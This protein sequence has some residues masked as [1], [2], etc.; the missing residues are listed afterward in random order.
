MALRSPASNLNGGNPATFTQ[1]T[2]QSLGLNIRTVTGTTTATVTD[3]TVL[4]NATT[5]AFTITL[6]TAASAS[7]HVMAFKKIDASANA[8]TIKGNGTELID[9]ANTNVLSAQYAFI[10]IQ[11][12]GTQWWIL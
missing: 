11:S 8:V 6:P 10:L 2:A 12:D 1:L 7:G 4:G 5:A 3:F 9:A